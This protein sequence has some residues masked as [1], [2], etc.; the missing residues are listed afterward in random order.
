MSNMNLVQR[1]RGRPAQSDSDFRSPWPILIGG[2]FCLFFGASVVIA[3]HGYGEDVD[4]Y[5]MLKTW[6]TMLIDGAYVPSRFQGD[7]VP[8][9]IIGFLASQFGP[10][11]PNIASL[12]L[13]LAA[14]AFA[15]KI[16]L[17][18][19]ADRTLVYWCL[20]TVIL[21]PRWIICS[22]TPVDY[23]Y[24]VAFCLLGI[25]L[26]LD[27]RPTLAALLFA[28]AAGSRISY[29]PLG[30]AALV[31][32]WYLE[33]CR[34]HRV[35]ILSSVPVYLLTGG[36]F[37][38]PVMIS[39]HL[40]FEFLTAARPV[41]QGFP[42]LLARFVYKLLLLYGL[43]GTTVVIGAVAWYEMR[44][45]KK[46][47]DLTRRQRVLVICSF[48]VIAFHLLLFL[49][50]PVRVSYLL[51]VLL[52]VAAIF[53]VYRVDYRNLLAISLLEVLLCFIRIEPLSIQHESE[54]PCQAV[55]AV[56]ARFSPHLAP[57]RLLEAL[58]GRSVNASCNL[59]V[60]R[61]VPSDPM[62]ALPPPLF[63]R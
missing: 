46:A 37:Y 45:R 1:E 39:S 32:A 59:A 11:G 19:T 42:G 29:V 6:Q 7:I 35:A 61:I 51:P 16:L 18:V 56:G 52:A 38:L 12:L 41:W 26:L 13:S 60:L 47:I 48:A 15:A 20:L 50:I 30:V 27:R 14:A 33:A 53:V 34:D 22:A 8:E 63:H 25:L 62:G 31:T 4:T 24:P 2:L 5:L 43:A 49:W 3:C 54:L 55:K 58:E 36:L 17:R 57:G 10:Y 28:L 40:T 21:N 9:I 23:I 44:R